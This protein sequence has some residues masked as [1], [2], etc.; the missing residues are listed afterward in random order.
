[1]RALEWLLRSK[2]YDQFPD[3]VVLVLDPDVFLINKFSVA[4]FSCIG[5]AACS[6]T[7]QHKEDTV[8]CQFAGIRQTS[9]GLVHS[10]PSGYLHVATL[11]LDLGSVMDPQS[12]RLAP[13]NLDGALHDS[14]GALMHYWERYGAVEF[15]QTY[16]FWWSLGSWSP[17][18]TAPTVCF[19]EHRY[20]SED[21][22]FSEEGNCGVDG[23]YGG[24]SFCELGVPDL[25][26]DSC[27]IHSRRSSNWDILRSLDF[28]S[29][30]QWTP[31]S[32]KLNHAKYKRFQ[33]LSGFLMRLFRPSDL[34]SVSNHASAANGGIAFG[35]NGALLGDLYRVLDGVRETQ[36]DGP[37]LVPEG[38][39]M[40]R[41]GKDSITI[42]FGSGYKGVC[43]G[44]VSIFGHFSHNVRLQ[45]KFANLNM[46]E[47]QISH[48]G[49]G[50]HSPEVRVRRRED[51]PLEVSSLD[52]QPMQDFA[53]VS[54]GSTESG[55]LLVSPGDVE[56]R[57]DFKTL[58]AAGMEIGLVLTESDDPHH[59]YGIIGEVVAN[60]CDAG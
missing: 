47:E 53:V 51:G 36:N 48:D 10:K 4:E 11:L 26:G 22:C 16:G 28:Q 21:T 1:M 29:D 57:V 32:Y 33:C 49:Q 12:I 54:G 34:N 59:I 58:W 7:S 2:V 25:I 52:F 42:L 38:N 17:E 45:V 41:P 43:V 15:P 46:S 60:R 13:V 20:L 3:S 37:Y 55:I 9:A 5:G 8:H 19:L 35:N 30:T 14:G 23:K 39:S 18:A 44:S 6:M 27:F 24:D 31:H 56:V 50:Q 40:F